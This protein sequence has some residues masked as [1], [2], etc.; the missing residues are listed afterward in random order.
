MRGGRF[1][2]D[3]AEQCVFQ[4]GVAVCCEDDHVALHLL[5]DLDDLLPRAAEADDVLRP[6]PRVRV[7][8]LQTRDHLLAF[9]RL[10]I[11]GCQRR[12]HPIAGIHHLL[13]DVDEHDLRLELPG[14]CKRVTERLLRV[15]GKINRD[16]DASDVKLRGRHQRRGCGSQFMAGLVGHDELCVAG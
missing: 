9:L 2:R 1:F 7:E 10:K 11:R 5:R 4:P 14:E 12:I 3:A 16:E 6:D 13:D 15:L 8:R